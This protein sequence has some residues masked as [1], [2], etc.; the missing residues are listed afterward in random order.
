VG[1]PSFPGVTKTLL[2]LLGG[3]DCQLLPKF[4][5]CLLS[6]NYAEQ[7]HRMFRINPRESLKALIIIIIIINTIII[8]IIIVISTYCNS[9]VTRWQ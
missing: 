7:Q 8:I 3:A 2:V 6:Q 4:C 1:G 9:V 5:I